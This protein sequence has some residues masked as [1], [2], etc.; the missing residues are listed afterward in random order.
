MFKLF[1]K[2]SIAHISLNCEEM[3]EFSTKLLINYII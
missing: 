2:I 3:L 1:E